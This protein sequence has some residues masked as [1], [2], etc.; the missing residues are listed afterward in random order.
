MG[1]WQVD[2]FQDSN[3]EELS[4]KSG[5]PFAA[6]SRIYDRSSGRQAA[7]EKERADCQRRSPAVLR[8]RVGWRTGLPPPS[9]SHGARDQTIADM[10]LKI[11]DSVFTP[12]RF[13]FAIQFQVG[14]SGSLARYRGKNCTLISVR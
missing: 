11:S 13:V 8:M 14:R 5:E 12:Y 10:N 4:P 3:A 6:N 1:K 2:R 9:R 7:S